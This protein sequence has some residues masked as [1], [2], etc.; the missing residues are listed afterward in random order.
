MS[1]TGLPAHWR[2]AR[3]TAPDIVYFLEAAELN[4]VAA[5]IRK[6]LERPPGLRAMI[7]DDTDSVDI[8]LSA[9]EAAQVWELYANG[10]EV[11]SA[12]IDA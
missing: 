7:E 5:A 8:W 6:A 11:A 4:G 1:N 3:Q 2:I 12:N 10:R 9:E